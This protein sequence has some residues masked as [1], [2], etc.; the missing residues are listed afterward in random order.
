[1]IAVTPLKESGSLKQLE[2][3]KSITHFSRDF[4][5]VWDWEQLL[6][7]SQDRAESK[8]WMSFE[9]ATKTW[10]VALILRDLEEYKEAE[11]RLREAIKGYKITFG[12]KQSMLKSRYGL[13]PLSWTA[14]NGYNDV[15]N[16]L[17]A[18]DNIDPDLKDTQ[19]GQTPLSWA[20]ENG[21]EAVVKLL[22]ETGKVEVDSKDKYGRIPLSWA[23]RNGHEAVVQLLLEK[24]AKNPQ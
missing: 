22:L 15:V 10:N 1:V 7:E 9:Q 2:L 24:G 8:N 5:L 6:K 16:L 19:Y 11:K 12:E 14:G 17:L 3:S 21:H 13:T 18:K 4:L 23:A 20:A